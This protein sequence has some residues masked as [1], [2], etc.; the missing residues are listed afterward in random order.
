MPTS[1]IPIFA[2]TR[3]R[4][5]GL[6]QRGQLGQITKKRPCAGGAEA[7]CV[8]TLAGGGLGG[9]VSQPRVLALG[10]E[11]AAIF[12]DLRRMRIKQ[13]RLRSR[14]V[15]SLSQQLRPRI[16]DSLSQHLAQLSLS[17]RRFAREGFVP[18]Q[19]HMGMPERELNALAKT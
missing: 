2:I 3:Q 16:A 13:F 7:V 9:K 14:I 11:L 19:W 6:K 4:T 5:G 18:H 1:F 12:L 17:L 15:D 10:C 8:G